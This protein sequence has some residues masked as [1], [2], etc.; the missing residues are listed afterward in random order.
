MVSTESRPRQ[1]LGARQRVAENDLGGA[2]IAERG[3]GARSRYADAWPV[4]V[5]R[6]R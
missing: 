5:R 4:T 2:F 3:V 1:F 6:L